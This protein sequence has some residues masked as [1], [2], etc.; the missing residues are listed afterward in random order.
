MNN[1]AQQRVRRKRD[2]SQ[3]VDPTAN[4]GY[5]VVMNQTPNSAIN[6]PQSG[7]NSPVK[8]GN[9]TKA[10]HKNQQSYD[11]ANNQSSQLYKQFLD[12]NNLEMGSNSSK[13]G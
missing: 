13:Y 1:H 7:N 11:F 5:N 12:G 10:N 3:V 6:L 9:T 2:F 8:T 4:S